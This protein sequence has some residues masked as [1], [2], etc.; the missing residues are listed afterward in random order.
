MSNEARSVVR[1]VGPHGGWTT[2]PYPRADA[3]EMR[4]AL[5]TWI[6]SIGD[7]PTLIPFMAC[8]GRHIS[9]RAR[10]VVAVELSPYVPAPPPPQERTPLSGT[11]Q[12]RRQAAARRAEGVFTE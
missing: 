10:D 7:D 8:G 9:F 6:E 1:V 4:D 12:L 2:K 3:E 11:E 5:T